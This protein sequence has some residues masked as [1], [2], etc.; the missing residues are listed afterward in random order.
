MP[1]AQVAMP[2][3]IAILGLLFLVSGKLIISKLIIVII[4]RAGLD[5]VWYMVLIKGPHVAT[6]V[7]DHGEGDGGCTY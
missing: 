2:K 7:L 3:T 1:A 4:K 5:M 6:A